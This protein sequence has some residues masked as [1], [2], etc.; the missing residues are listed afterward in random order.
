MYFNNN[1]TILITGGSGYIAT[2]LS[3]FLTDKGFNVI[4]I[5]RS[6]EYIIDNKNIEV[7]NF[8][9]NDDKLYLELEHYKIDYVIQTVSD[10]NNL[11]LNEN[12]NTICE[13]NVISNWK[14]ANFF[15]KK[16]IKLFMYFSTIHVYNSNL[17]K[18]NNNTLCNPTSIYGLTHFLSEN[19]NN[20][21]NNISNTKFLNIR[22]SNSYGYNNSKSWKKPLINE[23]CFSAITQN[24]IKLKNKES[25]YRDFIYLEDLANIIYYLISNSN[26]INYTHLN[27]CSGYS[28]SLLM[29]S[30]IIKDYCKLKFDQNIEIIMNDVKHVKEIKIKHKLHFKTEMYEKLSYIPSF[31]I[32]NGIGNTIDEI[33]KIL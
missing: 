17:K 21:Y 28:Y 22:L 12:I 31:S 29:V 24:K 16:S 23:F 2:K 7:L 33:K 26:L 27:L 5:V 11:I 13:N 1:E 30:K 6:S 19:I 25:V 10:S 14:I 18:V 9:L 8:D 3:K 4:L 32:F 20:F 15:S